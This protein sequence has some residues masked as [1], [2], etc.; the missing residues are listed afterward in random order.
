MSP[1]NI[2]KARGLLD[3]A[4]S[5]FDDQATIEPFG[6]PVYN[7]YVNGFSQDTLDKYVKVFN[8]GIEGQW[9]SNANDPSRVFRIVDPSAPCNVPKMCI[10]SAMKKPSSPYNNQ[11]SDTSPEPKEPLNYLL[12]VQGKNANER[13]KIIVEYSLEEAATSM[14]HEAINGFSVVFTGA[15]FQSDS[16][17]LFSERNRFKFKK[18][19]DVA[20]LNGFGS[21][22]YDQIG[23][24]C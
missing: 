4:G 14:L 1:T 16:N 23:I 10:S 22:G 12:V 17:R 7:I 5:T 21:C 13:S 3:R 18:V 24:I 2:R 11:M 20:S 8:H 9:L 15:L 6:R 19:P